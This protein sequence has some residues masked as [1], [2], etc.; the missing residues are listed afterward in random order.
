MAGGVAISG[1]LA[2]SAWRITGGASTI[3]DFL[4]FIALIGIAA[5]ELR[6]LG[7]ISAAAQEGR[8]AV[9]RVYA[10]VDAEQ[11]TMDKPD[12]RP[13]IDVRGDISFEDV[14]F[15]YD[16]GGETL[17]G[18]SLSIKAGET[19]A[20]V[21]PSGA[22]KSTL[23]NLLL[24]LY[25]VS[26]GAVRVDA[27]DIRTLRISNLRVS[28]ALV[29]QEPALF[30]DTVA[31][32][33]ALG[34]PGASRTD[35]EAALKA[36]SADEFVSQLPDGLDT[37][38]GERGS[39]LSG[40]QR[41]RIALARA[42]LRDAPI[43][44]LDEATS[45]LDAETEQLVGRALRDFA[46]DR[47]VLVIAHRPSTVQWADRVIVIENGRVVEEGSHGAL[48]GAGGAYARLVKAGLG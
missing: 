47:T 21:G 45:A 11:S 31:A 40:G 39:R 24:R 6:S 2:F 7:S 35:I 33:I 29:E 25:D 22:G 42:I 8:A 28:M 14:H 1:V 20:I 48:E 9:Q 32:N 41:Q 46:K 36:A 27:Q 15:S 16:G 37:E 18:L 26:S 23:F 3:G 4:G 38:V 30:D 10:L 19:V 13:L 44:L 17:S 5:P 12:A 43:L 34:R